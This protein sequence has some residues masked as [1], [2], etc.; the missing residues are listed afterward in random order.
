MN[1]LNNKPKV[2]YGDTD[3]QDFADYNGGLKKL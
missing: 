3:Y 1:N 2:N